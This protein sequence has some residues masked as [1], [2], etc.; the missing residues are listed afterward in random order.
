MHKNPHSLKKYHSNPNPYKLYASKLNPS[1]S[2]EFLSISLMTLLSLST[3][4]RTYFEIFILKKDGKAL[5][6]NFIKTVWPAI[7]RFFFFQPK[8]QELILLKTWTK[9]SVETLPWIEGT[10]KYLELT[11]AM[12]NSKISASDFWKSNSKLEEQIMEDLWRFTTWSERIQKALIKVL[13]LKMLRLLAFRKT[14]SHRSKI[15]EILKEHPR[16]WKYLANFLLT[17]ENPKT[18]KSYPYIKWKGRLITGQHA[19]GLN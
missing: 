8:S 15:C 18:L 17:H 10:P 3:T 1:L 12:L 19:Y 11:L 6:T 2:G 7:F 9:V 4:S 14:M 16:Q 13:K 5:K